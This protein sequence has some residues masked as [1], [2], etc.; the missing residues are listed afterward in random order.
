MTEQIP[1]NQ[2]HT[3]GVRTRFLLGA[4]D[5]TKTMRS[6]GILVAKSPAG[7]GVGV[8]VLEAIG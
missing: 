6:A 8:A 2:F 5:E 3:P 1:N 7:V 4:E